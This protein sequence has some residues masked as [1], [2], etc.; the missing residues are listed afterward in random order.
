MYLLTPTVLLQGKEADEGVREACAES[1]MVLAGCK[2][3]RKALWGVKGPELMQK[4]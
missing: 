3:G 1:V 2:A 4:G